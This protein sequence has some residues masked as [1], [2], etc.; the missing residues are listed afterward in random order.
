MTK[1]YNNDR[2]PLDTD[3]PASDMT[4]AERLQKEMLACLQKTDQDPISYAGLAYCSPQNCGRVGCSEACWF[5]G[6][7]RQHDAKADFARLL[8]PH[9]RDLYRVTV[10]RP[11]WNRRYGE[12]LE[13]DGAAGQRLVSH[14]LNGVCDR[15]VVGV[16][17]FKVRPFGYNNHGSWICEIDIITAGLSWSELETH[18]REK[19]PQLVHDV[20]V[21]PVKALDTALTGVLSCNEPAEPADRHYIGQRREFY[22]WLL[23]MKVGSRMIRYSR[24]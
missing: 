2:R 1:P 21:L 7:R 15:R 12:L 9:K 24:D 6:L 5:G 8:Q 18:F 14:V 11:R 17:T 10:L 3:S 4:D 13:V 23:N 16:G 20:H 19:R 22:S